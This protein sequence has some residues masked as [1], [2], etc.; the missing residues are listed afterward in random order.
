VFV[1]FARI[2]DRWV[3]VDLPGFARPVPPRPPLPPTGYE[4]IARDAA[5]GVMSRSPVASVTHETSLEDVG[6]L[7]EAEL[8]WHDKTAAVELVRDHR[9]LARREIGP[10]L[11][12]D[13]TF[14][15]VAEV[16]ARRG[17]VAYRVET[18]AAD[19]AV[20]VRYTCDG[21]ATWTATV[22]R[23]RD[24]TIDVGELVDGS[25]TECR[26]EVLAS[27]GWRTAI[28]RSEVFSVRPREEAITAWASVHPAANG[29]RRL[30]LF[31]IAK[32]GAARSSGI[33]WTS[34]VDGHLGRGA[35]IAPT[36]RPGRH[37]IDVRSDEPFVQPAC[38]DV[39]IDGS[40]C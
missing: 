7:L 40:L 33:S 17:C 30:E 10:A 38:V 32:N 9:V 15:P 39:E 36:L 28:A 4:V 35:R 26:L 1:S 31:G 37:R 12:L 5:G 11:R 29:G 19:V 23:G 2:R 18:G 13:V 21:G 34:D 22:A 8:P 14:P 3:V 6:E 24:R 25:G 16:G 20:A 27:A